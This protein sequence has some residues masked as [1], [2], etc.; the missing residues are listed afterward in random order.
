MSPRHARR[1]AVA[2]LGIGLTLGPLGLAAAGPLTVARLKYGG[3]GD[4][5]ANPTG[6]VNLIRA[7]NS[8][9]GVRLSPT[10][11]VV[12]PGSPR[13]FDYP[14]V[15]VTGHGNIA[16]TPQER[17]NLRRYLL[18]GGFM[19]IDDN[20]GLD[21]HLRPELRRLFP[22]RGL[23]ELPFSHP[24]YRCFYTFGHGLPKIH[25][26]HGGPPHGYGILDRGRAMVFYSYNT[27]INDG[28]EDAEVHGDPAPVRE[29]ALRMGVNLVVYAL[30]H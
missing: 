22:D 3:G 11:A 5:Y 9:T 24:V 8:R 21:E 19:H 23:V 4:W 6:L 30:T 14:V 26:H 27:D 15:F 20:Y 13:L 12:E 1:W 16:L 7:V 28:W 17:R 18:G 29:S 2:L 25:E 10:P